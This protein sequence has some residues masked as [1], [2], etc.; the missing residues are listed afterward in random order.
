MVRPSGERARHFWKVFRIEDPD[1]R[2]Q[3]QLEYLLQMGRI[4][5]SWTD[6]LESAQ[7][8]NRLYKISVW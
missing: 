3:R 2:E 8:F 7:K 5:E 1:G 4:V 6:R